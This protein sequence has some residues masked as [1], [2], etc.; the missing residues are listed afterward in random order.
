MLQPL[1][2]RTNMSK[3]EM[4]ALFRDQGPGLP[5]EELSR[6]TAPLKD[7]EAAPDVFQ[8]RNLDDRPHEK[9]HHV[10][11]LAEVVSVHKRMLD[12]IEIF[13]VGS[14]RFVLDGHCRL[15][16]YAQAGLDDTDEVPVTYFSGTFEEALLRAAEA[17]TK[18][19]LRMTPSE[20]LE[21]AWNLVCFDETG[22]LYSLREI[23]DKTGTGKSTVGNMRRLLE[24]SD[25][26]EFDPRGFSWQNVKRKRRG[27]REINKE[28]MNNLAAA[29]TGR[30]RKAFGDKP[31]DT[32][33]LFF[34]ALEQAYPQIV[35]EC[36][37]IDWAEESG[38][39]EALKETREIENFKF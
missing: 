31:N 1:P 12:P 2:N 35:P 18:D 19:K 21:S 10:K 6:A 13:V 4:Q 27:Q 38:A 22:D 29:W 25:K 34:R 32:P 26:L 15:A 8:Y 28:W 16:A 30:L 17:N 7:L 23:A 11:G 39:L 33:S 14:R 36:M 37:P 3:R 24:N 9:E 20:K 5:P